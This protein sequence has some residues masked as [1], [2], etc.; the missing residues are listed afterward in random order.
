MLAFSWDVYSPSGMDRLEVLLVSPQ[1]QC[2]FN[3]PFD[4]KVR[5]KA[6]H[7]QIQFLLHREYT[8]SALQRP[9]SWWNAQKYSLFIVRIIRD[10]ES[11]TKILDIFYKRAIGKFL[12]LLWQHCR[13]PWSFTC[14]PCSFDSGR[15]GIVWVRR[16]WNGSADPEREREIQIWHEKFLR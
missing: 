10:Y 12:C 13:R 15:T 7:L 11:K 4:A 3:W 9:M 1:P 16:V 2:S 5:L 14:E 6:T 8:A